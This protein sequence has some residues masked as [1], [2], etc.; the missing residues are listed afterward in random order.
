MS[1]EVQIKLLN[2]T[3][4][5]AYYSLHSPC[6]SATRCSYVVS[7]SL[8]LTVSTKW[9]SERCFG[10]PRRFLSEICLLPTGFLVNHSRQ[11]IAPLGSQPKRSGDNVGTRIIIRTPIIYSAIHNRSSLVFCSNYTPLSLC[12]HDYCS[13]STN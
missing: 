12:V 9:N 3:E 10:L 1:S 11:L 6:G 2:L 13:L 8:R 4:H 5:Y 7:A